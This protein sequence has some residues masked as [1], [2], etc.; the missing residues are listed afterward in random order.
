M[1]LDKLKKDWQNVNVKS[2]V[3][4]VKIEQMIDNEGKSAFNR[5]VLYEKVSMIL[6]PFCGLLSFTDLFK[7][8]ILKIY[9]GIIC[10]VGFFWE[11]YKYKLLKGV[12]MLEMDILD[13]SNF[14]VKFR[15]YVVYEIIVTVLWF[16][17]FVIL[18]GY[19]EY[20]HEWSIK[21]R[22]DLIPVFISIFLITFT[23][24][25]FVTW[26]L[27]WKKVKILGKSIRELKEFEKD[28]I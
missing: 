17:S 19:L 14:Y 3:D 12:N 10:V 5:L 15:K 22:T 18:F 26:K 4:E 8:D 23:L 13:I 16:F 9:Y 7:Y 20:I 2:S 11:C 24:C 27:Y 6:L 1:D 25:I 21:G 28:N